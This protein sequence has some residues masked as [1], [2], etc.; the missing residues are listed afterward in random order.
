MQQSRI[1]QLKQQLQATR[2]ELVNHPLYSSLQTLQHI[3]QFTEYHVYAV[4]D[5][6]SL[7][8]SLQQ[9]LTCVTLP[10][11]PRGNANTRYLINEI[12]LGEETD[13]DENGNRLSHFELY[14]EAM[15][16]L[17]ANTAGMQH[18]LQYIS[19]GTGIDEA[20]QKLGLP[21]GVHDF[22][23]Y[24]FQ[25]IQNE[26]VHVQAAVFTFGREDLIPDM[27]IGLVKE[28]AQSFPEQVSIFRYY[29]ERHIE[30]DG[31]HHSQLAMQMV[32]ELCGEDEQKWQAATAAAQEALQHRKQLWNAVLQQ[33]QQKKMAAAN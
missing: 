33:V 29:L 7:L 19:N 30:V 14:L 20:L 3:R 28:L 25:V 9:Q 24:T 17:G 16:Q 22:V 11:V 2:N 15:H 6:M 4:W 10:W 26:P 31:D 8:K 21:K 18:L 5:F 13:V 27:F 32:S 12:V 23:R 1:E